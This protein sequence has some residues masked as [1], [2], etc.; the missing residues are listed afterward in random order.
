MLGKL[1]ATFT[2]SIIWKGEDLHIAIWPGSVH[3]TENITRFI[4]QESRSFVISVS[5]LMRKT[6]IPG[7]IP[8]ADLIM[9]NSEEILANGGSCIAGPDANWIIEPQI[10]TEGIFTAELDYAKVRKNDKILIRQ[11]IIHARMLPS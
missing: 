5:A 4:A 3:N 11:V 1:D 6:D 10:N 2:S 9:E 8:H 7:Y